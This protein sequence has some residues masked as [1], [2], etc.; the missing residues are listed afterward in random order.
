MKNVLVFSLGGSKYAIELR[1][2]REV[3]PLGHIT[4]VPHA[5]AEIA[6]VTNCRGAIVPVLRIP[7]LDDSRPLRIGDTAVL[8]EVEGARV[9]LRIDVVD[10]VSTLHDADAGDG[11]GLRMPGGGH[12]PLLDPPGIVRAALTATQAVTAEPA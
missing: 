9:A 8:L 7:D 10:A 3:M 12:V 5:P 1:W 4:P 6:G 11:D 2:V